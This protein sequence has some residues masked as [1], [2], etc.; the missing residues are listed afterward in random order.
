[1][2]KSWLDRFSRSARWYL[3]RAEADE[4]IDDYR[5]M[6]AGDVRSEEELCRDLGKPRSAVRLL[7]Q[8]KLYRVWLGVFLMLSACLVL[9]GISPLPLVD[10]R[11]WRYL[12]DYLHF[13]RPLALLGVV[14]AVV[15]FRWKGHREKKLPKAICVF[16]AAILVYFVT[17]MAV[18]WAWMHDPG[19]FSEMWGQM[20]VYVLWV[21]IGPEGYTMSR[22]VHMLTDTLMWIGGLGMVL[23]GMYALV[24]ARTEDRRWAGVYVLAMTAMLVSLST[25]A[26]MT[27]MD[28]SVAY[29]P[30][31]WQYFSSIFYTY[32]VIGAA[33]L[34]GTGVALC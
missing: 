26:L 33:G 20:P 34:V 2:K 22:A 32:T 7:V 5:E 25:L 6:L 9:P 24:K 1:M 29:P 4:V 10:Y 15:W 23:A 30:V 8:P 3:P 21:R 18:N 13:S 11:L 12:F 14:G 17:I 27:S 31:I 16:G 19:G 28:V